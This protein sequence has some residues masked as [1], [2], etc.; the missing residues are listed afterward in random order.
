[1]VVIDNINPRNHCSL[2]KC[3]CFILISRGSFL[4]NIAIILKQNP[5][6]SQYIQKNYFELQGSTSWN[7]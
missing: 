4:M 6:I 1:M 2:D 5:Y 7:D 3:V